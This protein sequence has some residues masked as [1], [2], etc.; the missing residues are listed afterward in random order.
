MLAIQV[1]SA[2][3]ISTPDHGNRLDYLAVVSHCGSELFTT[4]VSSD[5]SDPI[6]QEVVVKSVDELRAKEKEYNRPV[7]LESFK[8]QIM[9]INEKN[10]PEPVAEVRIPLSNI[11]PPQWY[12]LIKPDNAFAPSGDAGSLLFALTLTEDSLGEGRVVGFL[13]LTDA[14]K[15]NKPQ[16]APLY[17]NFEWSPVALIGAHPLPGPLCGEIL[18][19][20]HEHVEVSADD[21]GR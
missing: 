8:V 13:P 19:D 12:R 11:G 5:C 20:R 14:L 2:M 18:L 7:F 4:S 6:W 15:A 16:H 9:W 3:G 21:G 17:L 10:A 1:I